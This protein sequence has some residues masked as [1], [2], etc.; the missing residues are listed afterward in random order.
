MTDYSSAKWPMVALGEVCDV[1]QPKTITSNEIKES[2][3]YKVYGANGVIGYFDE[4]NH[5]EAEVAVT[6]R[7]A[8]CG[9]V[10]YTEPKSWIT[11]N[12]MVIKPKENNLNKKYL[13]FLLRGT[14]LSSVITGAA[15]PQITGGALK[16]FKIPLPPL[17]IQEQVVAELDGYTGIID[18]AKQI[19]Q[20]WKPKID[21][22]PEW[23]KVK[24]GELCEIKTGKK[25]V[26]S[27]NPEG[28]YPF[29]TCAK[30]HTYSD[31]F[32]FDTEA[33]LIAGNGDVGAIKYYK[34]KFEAY[35]RVYVLS[36]FHRADPMY[37]Y[38]YLDTHLKPIV[39]L[40]KLG[41]TMPYIKLGMLSDFDIPL[42][43][44]AIQKQIVEKIESERALVVSVKKLIEIYEQKT[45][46]AIA[47]LWSE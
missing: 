28:E 42:P 39:S 38:F 25:D 24:L 33:L 15:Q 36:D 37:L 11:G 45:K 43:P 47:K 35:Q 9:T 2:G 31:E 40:Q 41:N 27:G 4:Y 1:Y 8:T 19:A 21:I 17:E 22:D 20:N 30:E 29:F 12:A 10:N 44:L 3:K 7:G 23:E 5:E 14:D 34:G 6:C 18:G 13:F 46:Q 26:N 16:P 32:S